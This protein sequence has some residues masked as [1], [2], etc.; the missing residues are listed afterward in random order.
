MHTHFFVYILAGP[1]CARRV[2][3][4][5]VTNDLRRRVEEHRCEPR[6]FVARYN[7]FALVY[8][9]VIADVERAIA[10]EK[11]VKGWRREKKIALIQSVNPYWRDLAAKMG[12]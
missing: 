1:N 12:W 7:L 3:Y 10:R 6:G 9:E 5:G 4:T 8:F 2:L 11:Q